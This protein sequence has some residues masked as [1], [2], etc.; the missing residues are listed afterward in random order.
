L[1]EGSEY[2][3]SFEGDPRS[4]YQFWNCPSP[5]NWPDSVYVPFIS[6]C[7]TKE[8]KQVF[9]YFIPW[10]G[11]PDELRYGVQ[12]STLIPDSVSVLDLNQMKAEV[13]REMSPAL[14]PSAKENRIKKMDTILD[15]KFLSRLYRQ[16]YPSDAN[17][18][19]NKPKGSFFSSTLGKVSIGG[20]VVGGIIVLGIIGRYIIYPLWTKQKPLEVFKKDF[21]LSKK[22]SEKGHSAKRTVRKSA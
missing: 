12:N 6:L 14:T 8:I 2:E 21:R 16:V 11:S 19:A 4:C 17:G 1:L 15:P 20:A 3:F 5:V 13:I 7:A 22:K 9:W 18:E 10:D